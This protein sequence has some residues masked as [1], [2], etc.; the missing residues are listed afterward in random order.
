[1]KNDEKWRKMTKNDEKWRKTTKTTKNDEKRRKTT[2]ITKNDQKWSK[3]TKNEEKW[4]KMTKTTKN[5]VNDER[6]AK[7]DEKRRKMTKNDEKWQKWRKMT[8]N[9]EKMLFGIFLEAF[10]RCAH[11]NAMRA[12]LPYIPETLFPSRTLYFILKSASLAPRPGYFS[13][14]SAA[15]L[16]LYSVITLLLKV[17]WSPNFNQGCKIQRSN[18][19]QNFRQN[20]M[21]N[22]SY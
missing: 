20:A 17:S 16:F 2:K 1:M 13:R 15:N 21:P 9:D 7:N 11:K 6:T 14:Y 22:K 12:T 8:K 4:R 19:P 5:D 3:M 18:N 10:N